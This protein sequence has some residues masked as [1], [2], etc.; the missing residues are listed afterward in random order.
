MMVPVTPCR[1]VMSTIPH[2]ELSVYLP[3]FRGNIPLPMHS[4]FDASLKTHRMALTHP[5]LACRCSRR[6]ERC[7]L[8]LPAV[9]DRK[10]GARAKPGER[11]PSAALP[12]ARVPCSP[13]RAHPPCH[14]D[15]YPRSLHVSPRAGGELATVPNVDSDTTWRISINS[16]L[17]TSPRQLSGLG[18]I[19]RLAAYE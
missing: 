1:H 13:I 6:D 2:P 18:P 12:Y 4:G 16:R 7:P 9:S 19:G 5:L 11:G 8:W 15:L 17:E 14:Q 3:I 10:N